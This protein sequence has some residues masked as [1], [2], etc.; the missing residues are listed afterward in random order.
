MEIEKGIVRFEESSQ[1]VAAEKR[2]VYETL[3]SPLTA[4]I[5]IL[6]NVPRR[7][8]FGN[9]AVME[10]SPRRRVKSRVLEALKS[11]RRYLVTCLYMWATQ[12]L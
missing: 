11:R 1:E 3:H 8:A 7:Q 4:K 2:T 5:V 6:S 10:G 9:F 12:W